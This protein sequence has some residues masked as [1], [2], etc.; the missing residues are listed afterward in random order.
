MTTGE[1][2]L[3]RSSLPSG[4]ALAHL[5]AIQAGSGQGTIFA[6]RFTVAVETPSLIVTRKA[7]RTV[8]SESPAAS[9]T[10]QRRTTK[11]RKNVAIF[12]TTPT[13]VTFTAPDEITVFSTTQRAVATTRLASETIARKRTLGAVESV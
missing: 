2:L 7:K 9:P 8:Q 10:V 5:L 13:A 4:T 12:S 1:Y 11:P 6:S 3:S